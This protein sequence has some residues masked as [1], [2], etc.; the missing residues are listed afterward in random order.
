MIFRK[1]A[2]ALLQKATLCWLCLAL[3]TAAVANQGLR[4]SF[5]RL[6]SWTYEPVPPQS[7]KKVVKKERKYLESFVPEDVYA[8]DGKE[9]EIV[10]YM[11][12][13]SI[14]GEKV[15]DFLLM[16][17]TGACCFGTMPPLNG[18]VSA[19]AKKG[20]FLFDNMP[21]LIR[22]RFSVEE[23]WQNGMFSH[24]YHVDAVEVRLHFNSYPEP[25]L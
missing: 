17:D 25:G 5:D 9:V 8:L 1:Q 19:R 3:T 24:L 14:K 11:L 10:G 23:V 20:T 22:G 7:T 13:L 6:A 2:L 4:L 18:F 15:E 16:P 12:P 21:V